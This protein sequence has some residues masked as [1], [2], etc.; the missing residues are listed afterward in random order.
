V[1]PATKAETASTKIF[2]IGIAPTA[3]VALAAMTIAATM[4]ASKFYH[5]SSF[6]ELFRYV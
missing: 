5:I 2:T 6:I 4:A 3:G 1:A